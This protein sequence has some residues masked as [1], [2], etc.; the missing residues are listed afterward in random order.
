MGDDLDL[1]ERARVLADA[2]GRDVADILADLADDGILNDSH[3]SG[4]KDLIAELQDAARLIGAVQQIN[5]AASNNSVLNG[6]ENKTEVTVETTLE[7]DIVDRAIQNL[8]TKAENIKKLALIVA[9]VLLLITGGTM[10]GLG[11][12]DGAE[13]APDD[14]YFEDDSYGGCTAWDADNYDEYASWDDGT[15]YWSDDN[16]HNDCVN[17]ESQGSWAQTVPDEPHNIEVHIEVNNLN[18]DCPVEIEL[19]VSVY[20]NNSY[21][22]TMEQ[23]ELGRWWVEDEAKIK[24]RDWRIDNLGD[25]DWSFETRFIPIGQSEYCCEMTNTVTIG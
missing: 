20:L 14:I 10:N 18:P 24:V 13:D 12:F 25:G 21:E 9:P 16:S 4:E 8:T 1:M 11:F 7:G 2:T 6:G 19:M 15:C 22:F 5:I 17:L 23:D 3:R